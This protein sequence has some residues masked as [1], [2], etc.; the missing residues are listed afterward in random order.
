MIYTILNITGWI[1]AV[2][3]IAMVTYTMFNLSINKNSN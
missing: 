1:V 3:S 2:A